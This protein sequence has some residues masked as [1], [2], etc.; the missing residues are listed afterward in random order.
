[1]FYK[2]LEKYLTK[3]YKKDGMDTKRSIALAHTMVT[4]LKDCDIPF[5]QKLWCLKRGFRST[6]YQQYGL[7]EKN[8]MD[9][10]SDKQYYQLHPL[11]N[12]FAFWINDKLTLKYMLPEYVYIDGTSDTKFRL[13]PKYY[14]YVENDG[15]FTY[16]ED[17]PV[18]LKHD[19]YFLLNLIKVIKE[20]AMKPNNGSSGI[21]FV[22]LRYENDTIFWNDDVLTEVELVE[23]QDLLRGYIVIEYIHQHEQ[24]CKVW[25]SSENTLRIVAVREMNDKYNGGDVRIIS[26]YVRFGTKVSKGVCNMAAGGLNLSFDWET[27]KYG[28]FMNRHLKYC[29]DGNIRL[30]EHPDTH[31]SIIGEYIPHL[32]KIK[33]AVYEVCNHLSSLEYYGLD[34]IVEQ[35]SVRV[36]EVNSLPGLDSIQILNGPIFRNPLAAPFFERKLK[37]KGI[38][39]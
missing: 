33:A 9:Y 1:M 19:K 30:F 2:V 24:H 28:D 5:A 20:V 32:D 18:E 35:D 17:A 23:K 22:H 16:L 27:G 4:D 34:I 7:T 6:R 38:L 12:H 13:M 39:K 15:H 14:L 11:N 8:Y 25:P 37:L 29:P 10:L 21:G 31:V 26:S 3:K 36:L